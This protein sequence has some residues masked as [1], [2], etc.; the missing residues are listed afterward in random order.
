MSLLDIFTGFM[1]H[2][3]YSQFFVTP[4]Y[5]T[6]DC[7]GKTIIVTGANVGLG[8]EAA[9]HYARL[10]AEKLIIA[11]RSTEKGEAAK[12]DIEASTKRSGAIEVW[13]LDLQDYDS[14]KAFAKRAEGLKR[15]DVV[16]ENAGIATNT[17]Q[18]VAGNESTVTTNVVSTFLLA[19]LMLPKLRETGRNFNITP[20]LTIVASDVH[21][22]TAFPE[23]KASSIFGTLNNPKEARMGDRYNASKLL[24][25]LTCREIAREHPVGQTKVTMNFV[26]PGWCHSQLMRE[27]DF[28]PMRL[29]QRIFCRTTEIGSRTLVHAGLAG[30][31]T[32]GKYLS[33]CKIRR[34]APLVEGKE[35]LGLQKRVWQE[36]SEKLNAIEPGVT[37]VLDV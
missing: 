22:V 29:I 28:A 11:C 6:T 21:C 8:K 2:F 33:N 9:T 4:Q 13:P 23:R 26:D 27:L 10:N 32:H 25:V 18:T 7:T 19:L 24:E 31:E 37:K 35:G 3:L 16:I 20:T 36:L 34:C 15:L 12:R 1:P 14:V 5:P 17:F 30:P